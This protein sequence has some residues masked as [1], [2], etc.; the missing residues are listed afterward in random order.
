M[1]GIQVNLQA[2]EPSEMNLEIVKASTLIVCH[3]TLLMFS[4]SNNNIL[5]ASFFPPLGTDYL[6]LSGLLLNP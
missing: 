3:F 4:P 6:V 5:W 2:T 1:D